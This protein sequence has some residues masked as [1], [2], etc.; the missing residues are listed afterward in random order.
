MSSLLTALHTLFLQRAYAGC[1]ITDTNCLEVSNFGIEAGGS[2]LNITQLFINIQGGLFAVIMVICTAIFIAGAFFFA[3][4]AGDE[5]RKSLGK[6][7]M[8]GAVIGLII[9]VGAKAIVNL[10]FNFIYG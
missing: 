7:L 4:S 3:I 1:G 6:D 2:S 5:Q 9:V 8:V 10:T